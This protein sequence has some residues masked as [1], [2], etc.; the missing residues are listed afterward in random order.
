METTRTPE[1]VV[2]GTAVVT[3]RVAGSLI[4]K[5]A[6]GGEV[7]AGTSICTDGS[8][9]DGVRAV[10]A[11]DVVDK[12]VVE[13]A[14]SVPTQVSIPLTALH[15]ASTCSSCGGVL[16]VGHDVLAVDTSYGRKLPAKLELDDVT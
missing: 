1:P 16:A 15:C 13:M 12:A 2:V 3:G 8:A 7:V 6:G 4:K 14:P 5:A 9:S 10:V 11:N